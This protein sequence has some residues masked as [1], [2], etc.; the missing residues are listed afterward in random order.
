MVV[1]VDVVGQVQHKSHVD[2]GVGPVGD[3]GDGDDDVA[4]CA[5]RLDRGRVHAGVDAVV[6]KDGDGEGT[7]QNELFPAVRDAEGA[8]VGEGRVGLAHLAGGEVGHGFDGEAGEDFD[9]GDVQ[10]FVGGDVFGGKGQVDE[11]AGPEDRGGDQ[12]AAEPV[13]GAGV[14]GDGEV[15]GEGGAEEGGGEEGEDLERGGVEGA[16]A[17]DVGPY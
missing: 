5:G 16:G 2:H 15:E 3:R 11:E 9:R 8:V 17:G 14:E 13:G 6:G 7:E 12:E 1:V 4:C 10:V